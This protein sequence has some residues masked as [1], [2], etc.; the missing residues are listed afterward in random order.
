MFLWAPQSMY[1]HFA[2]TGWDMQ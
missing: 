1:P 2:W